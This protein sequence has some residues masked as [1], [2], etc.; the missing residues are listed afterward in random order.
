ML[1]SE[2]EDLTALPLLERKR[3]LLAMMPAVECRLLYL[4]HLEAHGVDLFRVACE[5]DLGG[6]RLEVGPRH[7]PNRRPRDVVAED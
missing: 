2:G 1:S 5:R 4:D 6:H 7:L 3:R